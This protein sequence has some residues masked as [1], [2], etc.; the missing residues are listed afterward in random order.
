LSFVG[1]GAEPVDP[2]VC[3]V[4]EWVTPVGRIFETHCNLAEL[5]YN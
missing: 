5:A 1:V 3:L 4:Q 2:A